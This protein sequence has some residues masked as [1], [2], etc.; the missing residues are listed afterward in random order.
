MSED[1]TA[2]KSVSITE[3]EYRKWDELRKSLI[4]EWKKTKGITIKFSIPQTMELVLAN[5]SQRK[6]V[7]AE[8]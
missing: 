8:K 7:G 5:Y 6:K 3:D 2:Y 1:K 4:A